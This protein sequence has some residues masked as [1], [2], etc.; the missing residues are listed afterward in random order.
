MLHDP[1]VMSA[2]HNLDLVGPEARFPHVYLCSAHL[3]L[4]VS[5]AGSNRAY[6]EKRDPGT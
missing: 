3:D 5:S 6:M 1:G 4:C 2:T